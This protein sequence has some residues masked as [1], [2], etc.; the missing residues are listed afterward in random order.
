[1]TQQVPT[2]EEIYENIIAQLE[3]A[4]GTTIPI[5]PKSFSRVLAKVLA[6]IFVVGY[7]FAGWVYLQLFV[8]SASYDSQTVNGKTF[9]PL[10]E[11]GK[12]IGV[13][14]PKPATRAEAEISVIVE[15]QNGNLEANSL[16]IKK[17]TGVI[18]SVIAT[19]PLNASSITAS[20]QAVD[21][22]QGNLGFGELGNLSA[23]DQLEFA[24]PLP[25]IN[26]T[27]TVTNV[28]V[29][30]ADQEEEQTYRER[31]ATRFQRR[32]QGG[33]RIDYQI[34]GEE[35]EGIDLVLPYTGNPSNN[36]MRLYSRSTTEPDGIPTA[37]QLEEVKQ[38]VL[39]DDQGLAN[40]APPGVL[41]ISNPIFR[42]GVEV[43]IIGLELAE[44]SAVTLAD[45]KSKIE[46]ALQ[47]SLLDLEPFILGVSTLPPR[48]R[49]SSAAIGGVIYSV[50]EANGA[51]FGS[52]VVRIGGAVITTKV[53]TEGELTKLQLPVVYS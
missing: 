8:N 31:V 2:I 35:V 4:I 53:L 40:R 14:G 30:A 16:L 1:M 42:T 41:V 49:V 17:D 26:G 39:F 47:D 34:W 25:F 37:T 32:P 51:F 9:S 27:A 22:D 3:G 13:G 6:A 12:L 50:T 19:V 29:V 43:E 21:D 36:Q 28:L 11:W 7:K 23:G 20:V 44:G 46:A 15:E 48:D 10:I 18:Y 24:N 33:A 45:V 5:F 38:S 52:Y